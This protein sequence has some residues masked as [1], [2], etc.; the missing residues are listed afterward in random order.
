MQVEINYTTGYAGTGKSTALI[1]KA[2]LLPVDTSVI[3]A[4]TH[5]ALA[6]LRPSLPEVIEVKTIHSLLGWIPT[7]NENAT[8]IEHIDA[9]VK[10]NNTLDEY[11]D[12][13]IDEAGMMSEDMLM[14]II[15][16]FDM[17]GYN[18]E[19][20]IENVEVANSIVILHL[21]LDPY[22]LLPVK[23]I[24]IQTEQSTTTNLTTQHRSESLDIVSLYTKFVEYLAGYTTDVPDMS[25]IYSENIQKLNITKF[26]EG[27]RLLAYT[28]K[29]V[30]NWNMLIAKQLG[31]TSFHGQQVQLGN[32][33]DTVTFKDWHTYNDID[34]IV[35]DF[36]SGKLILQNSNISSQYLEYS[37]DAL[38]RHKTIKFMTDGYSI[39]PVLVG[40]AVAKE[41]L[42]KAKEAAIKDRKMFKHVYT[43]G[44]AFS[45]DY[46]FATTVHKAQG[47]E[48]N[49]VFID[50]PDIAKSIYNG[51]Y[52]T[53]VRLMYVAISRCTHTLYI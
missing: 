12:I 15:S 16:K 21:Y 41:V 3:I 48:F 39:Y 52:G 47:S 40:T 51:Y 7:I 19:G 36:K 23:G 29:A 10:L 46:T 2:R 25:N 37:L 42:H 24:Q 1:E 9:T 38:R 43:L 53:Y 13:V 17:L 32:M 6:R 26:R 22:Q 28:N 4:P 50:A 18:A 5:K 33:L 20:D 30:G 44:R 27:D 14:E 49:S 8:K 45:M 11:T 31:I 34:D 35:K